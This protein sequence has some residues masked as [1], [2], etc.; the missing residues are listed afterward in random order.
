MLID[1]PSIFF[2]EHMI[3]DEDWANTPESVRRGFEWLWKERERLRAQTDQSSRNSSL[4]PSKDRPQHKR[5]RRKQCSKRKPGGQPGHPGVT[6]P[7]VPPEQLSAP[8]VSIRPTDCV[9]GHVFDVTA[10]L[11]GDPC[12]QQFYELPPMAPSITE[13]QLEHQTC[14]DCGRVV[15]APRPVGTPTLSLG[16]NA[17][18]LITL[19]TGQFHLSKVSVATLMSN[20]FGIPLSAAS[21]IAVEQAASAALSAPV[22]QAM[23]TVQQAPIKNLDES[24]WPQQRDLDQGAPD[25]TP[26][27]H[28]WLWSMTTPDAT[29][30]LIRRSRAQAVARELLGIEIDDVLYDIVVGSDRYG[31]YNWLPLWA[32]QICWAH[33]DRDFLALSQSTNALAQHIGVELLKQA[34][35]LWA[36]WQ[37]YRTGTL[38]FAQL[39]ETL[40]PVRATVEALLREG[41]HADAKTKT[42][43]HNL[44]QLEPALWTF[45]RVE[46][47]EPTNNLAER[48]QRHG[49]WK[50]D[51]TFGTQTSAG[52]R[53]VERI[54]TTIVTCR[55][56]G[57]NA[58]TYLTQALV[59]YY[60]NTQAPTLIGS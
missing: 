5:P 19:L 39:G 23:A 10:P 20:V 40:A 2:E 44:R 45:L 35:S 50:R 31:A 6:R 53:Y 46:G 14:P 57:K 49:V 25:G 15:R 12:R 59:A 8:P 58:L 18:A 34:D 51:R 9:C 55:Q 56:Q 22:A 42:L 38:T 29:I 24:G 37:A 7:L 21:V 60:H 3:P 33:L 41:H 16:P 11:T 1:I 47:V 26:L 27:K 30:Y 36:A 28:G 13:L 52:S 17:Q 32:R 48:S 54:L 43:C 4:P